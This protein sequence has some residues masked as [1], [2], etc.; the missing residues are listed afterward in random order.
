MFIA[1]NS[2][3]IY[4]VELSLREFCNVLLL[5]LKNEKKRVDFDTPFEILDLFI[6]LDG[7]S[8]K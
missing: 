2:F 5:S 7:S 4:E 3:K 6:I 1:F 8:T